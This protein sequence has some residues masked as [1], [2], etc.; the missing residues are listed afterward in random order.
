MKRLGLFGGRFDP[1]HLG[2]L[3]AAQEALEALA[4][5]E[6][7]FV[8]AQTPPH[9]PA[10][11]SAEDRFNM[12]LLATASHPAF[13]VSRLELGRTGPSY[14]FDTVMRVRE[15]D[16]GGKLF[17]ITGADAYA[18][19][20][21]WHRA[22]ELLEAVKMVAVSRPGYALSGLP[23]FYR[24]KVTLLD[25][26]KIDISSTEVRRRLSEGRSVRYLVPE[27]VESYLDKHHL[28]AE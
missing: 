16:P 11:A 27:P 26:L 3:L 10:V 9:K 17:F 24:D 4:L 12:T 7:W 5:D 15:G 13:R 2:H 22:P 14:T 23:E 28:Y 21:T 19:I 20:E 1:P 18:E 8:P 6:F 25:R